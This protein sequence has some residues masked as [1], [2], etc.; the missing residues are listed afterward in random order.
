MNCVLQ[1]RRTSSSVAQTVA[2]RTLAVASPGFA[3]AAPRRA[4]GRAAGELHPRVAAI[5]CHSQPCHR[6]REGMREPQPPSVP[7]SSRLSRRLLD[8][9]SAEESVVGGTEERRRIRP[10]WPCLTLLGGGGGGLLGMKE[11]VAGPRRR[12]VNRAT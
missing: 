5:S 11:A 12:Q 2:Q 10:P 1:K 3:E 4:V 8:S 9:P 7:A 6:P